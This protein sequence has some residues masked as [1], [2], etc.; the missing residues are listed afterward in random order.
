MRLD[1]GR[2][3]PV[4]IVQALRGDDFTVYGTGEQTRSFCHVSD[5]IAGLVRLAL[6]D[7]TDPVNLG[8]PDEITILQFA[9]AVRAAVGGSNRLT[10]RP[11]PVGDPKQRRPDITRARKLLQWEPKVPLAEGLQE[12]IA[13]FRAV[14]ERRRAS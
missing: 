13:F 1:D 12:T 10:F 5:L 9:E 8:N 14:A 11:L 3:V 6:S 7:V 4:F 2:V